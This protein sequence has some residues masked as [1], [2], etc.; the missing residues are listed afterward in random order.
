MVLNRLRIQ[1]VYGPFTPS[2]LGGESFIGFTKGVKG[3][4][5]I[6]I[7]ELYAKQKQRMKQKHKKRRNYR[8]EQ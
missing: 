6:T 7:G 2:P 4:L 3:V 1:V 5:I 8:G